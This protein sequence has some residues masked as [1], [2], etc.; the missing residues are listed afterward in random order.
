MSKNKVYDNIDEKIHVE[1]TFP[2]L[3]TLILVG[4]KPGVMEERLFEVGLD[5]FK[6]Q[7]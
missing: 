2:L 3:V 5:M 7:K 1:R 6:I 4:G